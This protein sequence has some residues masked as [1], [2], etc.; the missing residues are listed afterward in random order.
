M[1]LGS[2]L[3]RD[4]SE[5]WAWREFYKMDTVQTI[6]WQLGRKA[7]KISKLISKKYPKSPDLDKLTVKFDFYVFTI[8]FWKARTKTWLLLL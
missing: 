3:R 8:A 4:T 5:P 6:F 2:S 1:K 7:L